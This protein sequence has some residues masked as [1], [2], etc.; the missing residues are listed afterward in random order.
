MTEHHEHWQALRFYRDRHHGKVMG[1]CAGIADYFGW[2][3]TVTRLLTII[4]LFW[5]MPATL[6]VY[7]TLGFL[8]PVKPDKLYDWDTDDEFWRSMRSS[9]T[10]TFHDLR[11]RFREFELRVQR[12]EGYVTSRH[13]DLD[14]EFR[15]LED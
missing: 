7:F 12:M 13:Y 1:V 4:A 5:F 14:K 10:G 2:N 3:V 8:L 11:H 6:L 9:A 15:D